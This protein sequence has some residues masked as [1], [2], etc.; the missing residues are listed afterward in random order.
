M[1]GGWLLFSSRPF[2][3]RESARVA[4]GLRPHQ[5]ALGRRR[6]ALSLFSGKCCALF[7]FT[8]NQEEDAAAEAGLQDRRTAT[9]VNLDAPCLSHVLRRTFQTRWASLRSGGGFLCLTHLLR[10]KDA[11]DAADDEK[12]GA[13][14]SCALLAIAGG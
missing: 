11:G 4:F 9:R 12:A 7:R 14:V 2:F 13:S 1:L 6:S 8:L 3:V 5:A 10:A